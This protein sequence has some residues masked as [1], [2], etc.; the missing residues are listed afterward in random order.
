MFGLRQSRDTILVPVF[1]LRD[2]PH[3]PDT[4]WLIVLGNHG[5]KIPKVALN[6]DIYIFLEKII[7]HSI[8]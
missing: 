7:F 1:G 2:T 6:L 4:L 5:G 3:R 8:Q